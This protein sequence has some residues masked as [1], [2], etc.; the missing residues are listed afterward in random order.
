MIRRRIYD[1]H[2]GNEYELPQGQLLVTFDDESDFLRVAFRPAVWA[3]WSRPFPELL[4]LRQDDAPGPVRGGY[5]VE[6]G[7]SYGEDPH[8]LP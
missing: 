7:R 5:P 8:V 3:T 1:V 6:G 2:E 4:E